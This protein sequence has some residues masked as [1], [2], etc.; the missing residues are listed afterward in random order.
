MTTFI[1]YLFLWTEIRTLL[2]KSSLQFLFGKKGKKT[3]FAKRQVQ[4]IEIL[5]ILST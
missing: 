5:L 4:D 2:N 3:S 1:V